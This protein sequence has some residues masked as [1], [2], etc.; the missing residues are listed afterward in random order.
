MRE[1]DH[2]HIYDWGCDDFNRYDTI[3]ARCLE[4]DTQPEA[5][6]T[7]VYYN[8]VPYICPDVAVHVRTFF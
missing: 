5:E 4:Y 6:R 7:I 1:F 2:L 3:A 8:L